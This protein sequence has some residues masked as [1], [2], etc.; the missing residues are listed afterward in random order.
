[1]GAMM[2]AGENEART[3]TFLDSLPAGRIRVWI[4][5][6]LI[7]GLFTLAQALVITG[8]LVALGLTEVKAL[9]A[10]WQLALPLVGLEAFGYGL[11]GSVIGRSVLGAFG[12]AL[13]PVTFSWMLGGEVYWPPTVFAVAARSTLL[14]LLVGLAGLIYCRP[15]IRRGWG[16]SEDL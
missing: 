15:D 13:I 7:G 3:Q 9:P 14:V 10:G 12:W 6:V 8:V 4:T 16:G 1:C 11:F 2:V 5:K